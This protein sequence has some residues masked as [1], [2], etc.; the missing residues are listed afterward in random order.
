MDDSS[1]S[2][3][4]SPPS[5][6][7]RLVG[8]TLLL[9][10]AALAAACGSS[11]TAEP[12]DDAP[13]RSAP[14]G[15]ATAD[16]TAWLEL[17]D[18]A[19]PDGV[20]ASDIGV[21]PL[22]IEAPREGWAAP[23]HAFELTPDG[24][25][26][27]APAT[28]RVRLDAETP[29]D[30]LLVTHV[31]ANSVEL[32]TEIETEIDE[33]SGDVVVSVPVTHFSRLGVYTQ[34]MRFLFEMTP[35]PTEVRAV[36][37]ESFSVTVVAKQRRDRLIANVNGL[38]LNAGET[39]EDRDYPLYEQVQ[40]ED[41]WSLSGLFSVGPARR[42]SAERVVSPILVLNAPPRTRVTTSSFTSTQAFTCD[43]R[44]ANTVSYRALIHVPMQETRV[45]LDGERVPSKERP[46]SFGEV[47]RHVDV[48][49]VAP[50]SASAPAPNVTAPG[51]GGRLQVPGLGGSATAT[52]STA[53][54]AV[55]GGPLS[56]GDYRV[57]AKASEGSC[58]GH[59]TSFS[60]SLLIEVRGTASATRDVTIWDAR[61]PYRG[62]LDSTT[63]AFEA[64]SGAKY[65]GV[66]RNGFPDTIAFTVPFPGCLGTYQ[67]TQTPVP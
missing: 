65:S 17:P 39:A 57:T 20:S 7:P 61:T 15:P 38:I 55:P 62:K 12:A 3:L 24:L 63:G 16:G 4:P 23:S 10:V 13:A 59:P 60:K 58:E 8:A 41:Y 31:S 36:V 56:P 18:G 25:E 64:G 37:G 34:S 50:P 14:A 42:G 43:K 26:L 32:I 35:L 27:E 22:P 48:E 9:L 33:E 51:L 66:L 67:V 40:V 45:Q 29:L 30:G 54:A 49:C 46:L 44:G 28:L 6:R 1:V 52:P 19:L 11:E 21:A 5:P 53:P 47:A 2:R